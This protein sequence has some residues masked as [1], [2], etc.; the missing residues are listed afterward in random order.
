[1]K[2]HLSIRDESSSKCASAM[3]VHPSA[4]LSHT[5]KKMVIM[6]ARRNDFFNNF[7]SDPFDF[8]FFGTDE[9]KASSLMKTDVKETPTAYQL[10]VDLPGFKKENIEV[11]LDDGYLTINAHTEKDSED[12]EKDGSYLRKERFEGS[13][14]RSFYV[15]DEISEKD[16]TAKFDNGILKINVPKKELPKPEE[17][18]RLISIDD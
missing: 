7:L 17:T 1:M 8:G 6:L 13:C 14:R 11:S 4:S 2:V 16:I 10:D 5:G 9:N 18:K 12:K 15:G 3:E